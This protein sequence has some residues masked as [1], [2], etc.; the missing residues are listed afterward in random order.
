MGT[1]IMRNFKSGATR[2]S[3]EGKFDFEGFLSPIVLE[4][5][6]KYMHQNRLQADGKLRASD[7]WQ[8]G[9]PQDA[10]VKSAW[11]HFF[12]WWSEHRGFKSREGIEDAICALLFNLQGY[13]HEQLKEREQ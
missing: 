11:R 10:Y 12:D 4:A 8:K 7:N 3:N 5:Y 2:N 9:I 1:E 6:A 13:L